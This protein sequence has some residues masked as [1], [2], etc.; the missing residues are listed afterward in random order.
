MSGLIC[1]LKL[2][3]RLAVEIRSLVDA[4]LMGQFIDTFPIIISPEST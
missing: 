4:I 1:Y 2:Q 3:T